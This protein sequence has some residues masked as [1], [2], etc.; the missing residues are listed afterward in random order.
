MANRI[1]T[2]FDL[3]SKGFDTGIKSLRKEVAAADG[4]I[5]KMKVAGSGLGTL[6]QENIAAAAMAAGA[7][8]V[9]FGV[10][11]VQAFQDTALAAGKFSDAAGIAV[12]DASRWIEVSGDLGVSADAVQGAMQRMN[13]AIADGKPVMDEFGDAIVRSADGTV[14]SSAS[15]QNLVTQI[16]AIKDPTERAKAAQEAFG[17]SYGEIAE[18]MSMSATD[19]KSALDGVSEAKVIDAAEL[20]KAHKFRAAMDDLRDRLEN[21][22]FAVGEQIVPVLG[23]MA[24]AVGVVDDALA[25]LSGNQEGGGIAGL[26]RAAYESSGLSKF[27]DFVNGMGEVFGDSADEADNLTTAIE[28][29]TTAADDMAKM[30]RQRLVPALDDTTAAVDETTDAYRSA[31]DAVRALKERQDELYGIQ[32]NAIERQYDYRDA[33]KALAES[34]DDSK[35]SADDQFDSVLKASEAYATL[36]GA[37]LDSRDGTLRQI[38]SLQALSDTLE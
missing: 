13:K 17:K 15:F 1:T 36:G 34:L 7:A 33:V 26:V 19:L 16:G 27:V 18:L 23:E 10:K 30:Y 22:A 14:N 32:R 38:E 29:G 37:A 35:A 31:T 21:V 3:D 24:D 20:E 28:Y 9:T 4:A 25:S 11:S 2:I 5:E 12:D 6:L 8:L